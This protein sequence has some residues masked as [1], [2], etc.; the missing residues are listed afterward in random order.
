MS[1]SEDRYDYVVDPDGNGDYERIQAAIDDAK[2]FPRDRITIFLKEGV[3]E[4]KVTVHSW[5]PKIDLIGESADGTVITH[6][7]HFDRIDRGRN[8]TFFTY[9]L[10]VCGNDFRARNLT[11]RNSAGPEVGQAVALHVEADRAVFEHCRFVGNQDTVYAA[12]EGARQY[13]DDCYLEGTT[14]FVFGGATAV[15]ENCEVHSKADSYITAASTPRT[16]PFGFVFDNCTL[17]AE[18]DVSEVYLGRPWRDHAHVAFLRSHMGDH[19]HPAGWHDWSRPAVV[20]DVTY[21]EYENHGPGA[22]T[23]ERVSWSETLSSEEAAQYDGENVL[24]E[25]ATE[26]SDWYWHRAI[27]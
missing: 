27:R 23:A 10:R 12:G 17:T 19:I 2:S 25:E 7:D 18:P 11:V 24:L 8:S 4:E 5:N 22:R 9:T 21:A 20:D 15:F 6:D 3:Y 1:A 13:F 16:E 14:D 26:R